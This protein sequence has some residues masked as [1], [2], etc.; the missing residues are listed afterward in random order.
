MLQGTARRRLLDSG[1]SSSWDWDLGV[2]QLVNVELT[3]YIASAEPSRALVCTINSRHNG[4]LWCN[5]SALGSQPRGPGFDP[6][7]EW[8]NLGGFSDTLTPLV[9]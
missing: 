5:S 7:A 8:K 1:I 2:R 3:A 6:R 4:T 9:T